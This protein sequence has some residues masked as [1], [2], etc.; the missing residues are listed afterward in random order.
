VYIAT[1]FQ[2]KRKK[3]GKKMGC[4]ASQPEI[5]DYQALL[6]GDQN[7]YSLVTERG[8][9]FVNFRSKKCASDLISL[10]YPSKPEL[11]TLS[12]L[13]VHRA[14]KQPEKQCLGQRVLYDDGKWGP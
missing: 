9:D 4:G 11:N 6:L 5:Y 14:S 7:R 13:I 2:K 12:K 1:L 10:P 3:E 8:D